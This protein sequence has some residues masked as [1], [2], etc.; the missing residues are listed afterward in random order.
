MAKSEISPEERYAPKPNETP[1]QT[2]KRIE[3]KRKWESRQKE[4][5]ETLAAEEIEDVWKRNSEALLKADPK[6]YNELNER[7]LDIEACR[8]ELEEVRKGVRAVLGGAN[9]RAADLPESGQY[10]FKHFPRPD[11]CFSDFLD[12]S[13]IGFMN[14]REIEASPNFRPGIGEKPDLTSFVD[15]YRF[16]GFRTRIESWHLSNACENLIEYF[17]A[18]KDELMDRAVVQQAFDLSEKIFVKHGIREAIREYL[19]PTPAPEPPKAPPRFEPLSAPLPEPA[20][21]W[22]VSR[23]VDWPRSR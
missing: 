21:G 1:E 6:K 14:V 7:H 4:K 20:G 11:L 5:Q 13:K 3:A 10:H 18:T 9:L 16:F 2:K 15:L 17:I 22:Q 12:E 19:N 8:W 23:A